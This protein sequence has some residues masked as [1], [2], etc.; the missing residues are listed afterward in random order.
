[1][2]PPNKTNLVIGLVAPIGA[3]RDLAFRILRDCLRQYGYHCQ[4]VKLSKI[5]EEVT[6]ESTPEEDQARRAA[7]LMDGGNRLRQ[8]AGDG[9]LG[10]LACKTIKD[11]REDSGAT[12]GEQK[13]FVIDSLKHPNEVHALRNTYPGGFYLLAL[14]VNA[15]RRL[16]FLVEQKGIE[17]PNAKKLMARDESETEG[18]GQHTRDTFQLADFFLHY[19]GNEDKVRHS[20]ARV[21][22]LLFG[23][24]YTMP[25]FNEFAM[26]VAFASAMRSGDLSRQVG[27]VL[28]KD[29]R[30]IATGANEAPSFGGGA[31]WPTYD[32]EVEDVV[33]SSH[34]RDFRRGRDANQEVKD[35]ILEDMAASV[36]AP[37]GSLEVLRHSKFGLIS[38]FGRS[39]HAEMDALLSCARSTEGCS[40]A[41]LYS[42][43]FPCHNCAKHAISAGIRN[44]FYV[45]PY[46]K[47]RARQ[48]HDD[49][50]SLDPR[51][52][53]GRMLLRPFVGIG[54]RQ[55]VNCFSMSLGAGRPVERK[56]GTGRILDWSPETADLRAPMHVLSYI[57]LEERAAK[58]AAEQIRQILENETH[59]KKPTREPE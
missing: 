10:L 32:R 45:E 26:Y 43:T 37:A 14:Q 21:L 47:S 29:N 25:T 17:E 54:P 5:I 39:V 41:D 3:D 46:P 28:A 7:K 44:V 56:D 58:R 16:R 50:L 30:I 4:L 23:H 13:A 19:N 24:P 8:D 42:T 35:E 12:P 51:D 18:H 6:R 38:E 48:L 31:Y 40:G 33:E 22:R 2:I 52:R 57:D 49:A 36:G 1:M 20:I 55:Y 15:E 27:A 34:G 11:S 53:D 9:I 59:G